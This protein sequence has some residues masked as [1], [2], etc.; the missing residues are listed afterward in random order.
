LKNPRKICRIKAFPIYIDSQVIELL[1]LLLDETAGK[2][3]KIRQIE[4]M[5]KYK[6]IS[7]KFIA[8]VLAVRKKKG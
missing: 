6:T 8:K 7:P 4:N 5:L 2:N 1:I 3:Y